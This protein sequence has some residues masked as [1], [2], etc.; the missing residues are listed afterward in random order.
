MK[1]FVSLVTFTLV[2]LVFSS[3]RSTT[4]MST[5]TDNDADGTCA[6]VDCDDFDAA[7]N[8]RDD[9]GDGVTSCQGDCREDDLAITNCSQVRREVPVYTYYPEVCFD[10]YM[11]TREYSCAPGQ[12]FSEC[13]LISE[14]TDTYNSCGG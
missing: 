3:T 1:R 5:C 10:I 7:L 13:T 6:E 4:A 2:L 8:G 11:T 12:S 14:T 9:D